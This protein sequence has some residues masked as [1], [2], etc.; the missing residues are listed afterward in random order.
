MSDQNKKVPT[1][2]D[3]R[4]GNP[5][6]KDSLTNLHK[7][8]FGKALK[9]KDKYTR[10][11]E[12]IS[13]KIAH[14]DFIPW[15]ASIFACFHPIATL[16][17]LAKRTSIKSKITKDSIRKD[18]LNGKSISPYKYIT[19]LPTVLGAQKD[20][21]FPKKLNSTSLTNPSKP[22]RKNTLFKN[23]LHV[24]TKKASTKKV[25]QSDKQVTDD[26]VA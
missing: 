6:F 13:K 24:S 11:I 9:I 4:H 10:H 2:D 12:S 26:R 17:S 16:K 15:Y 25:S 23:L 8:L 22:E 7:A 19:H 21:Y 14:E 20:K 3:F 5:S 1:V 18:I